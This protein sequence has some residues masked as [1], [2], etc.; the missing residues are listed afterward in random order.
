MKPPDE[1][2]V[3]AWLRKAAEDRATADVLAAQPVPLDDAVCFHCQ[4]AAEK[5]LKAALVAAD[6]DPPRT[7]DL[8]QLLRALAPDPPAPEPVAEAL[9]YLKGFAVLSRYPH[10]VGSKAPDRAQ[11]ARTS[12]ET[13]TAWLENTYAWRVPRAP[14]AAA[15]P[16][17]EAPASDSGPPRGGAEAE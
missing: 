7:H 9:T 3:R 11:Q 5:L 17:D 12:I 4:Q 1:P 8:D 15:E 14:E 10:F 6:Q 13:V 16:P 2:D